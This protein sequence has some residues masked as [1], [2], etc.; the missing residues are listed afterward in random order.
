MD[1]TQ[2]WGSPPAHTGGSRHRKGGDAETNYSGRHVREH[3]RGDTWAPRGAG[4]KLLGYLSQRNYQKEKTTARTIPS[5]L[6]TPI[7]HPT[8]LEDPACETPTTFKHALKLCSETAEWQS[9]PSQTS[10]VEWAGFA[11]K[12]HSR[13]GQGSQ[14]KSHTAENF[15][16]F[17]F[18]FYFFTHL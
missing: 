8:H 10:P 11:T 9:L 1:Y 16:L 5:T 6:T 2:Q 15:F 3:L 18:F 17:F 7:R 14:L 4:H 12:R 13:G